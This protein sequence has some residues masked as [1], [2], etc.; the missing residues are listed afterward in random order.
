MAVWTLRNARRSDLPVLQ[1]FWHQM[2]D[3]HRELDARFRFDADVDRDVKRHLLEAIGSRH[4]LVLVAEVEGQ[5]VGYT[6]GWLH[7]RRPIYPAGRYGFISDLFVMPIWRRQGIGRGLVA[8]MLEWFAK[9]D[10]TDIELF[11]AEA[12]AGAQAF[13]QA[14]GF[15]P[16]LRLMRRPIRRETTP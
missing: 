11:V 5:V 9:R 7:E 3:L 4:A 1:S 8:G 2:M 6:L 14:M 13:W 12:N 16:F 15:A 10:V